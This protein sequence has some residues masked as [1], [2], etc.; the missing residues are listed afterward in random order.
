MPRIS[1]PH[2]IQTR[3]MI[4]AAFQPI[5]R[6]YR[7]AAALAQGVFSGVSAPRRRSNHRQMPVWRARVIREEFSVSYSGRHDP[8]SRFTACAGTTDGQDSPRNGRWIAAGISR[9]DARPFKRWGYGPERKPAK[10]RGILGLTR[11]RA[12][13]PPSSCSRIWQ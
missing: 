8:G 6:A 9:S 7:Q 1:S 4:R 2:G 12:T 13:M 5:A 11:I 10:S 3:A